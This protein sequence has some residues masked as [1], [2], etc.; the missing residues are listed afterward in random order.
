[1]NEV[2]QK[3]L[4]AR[5]RRQLLGVVRPDRWRHPLT[6]P[7]NRSGACGM[8]AGDRVTYTID[9]RCGVADE[10]LHDGDAFV[11]FDDGTCET[12][13]W[14]WLEPEPGS[15]G[16]VCERCQALTH[17][18]TAVKVGASLVKICPECFSRCSGEP[19]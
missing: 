1:M 7:D 18:R 9:G 2:R 3:I 8:M 13:K 17:A 15:F 5:R 14:N 19:S 16:F 12:V 6:F 10:F 11:S 4:T